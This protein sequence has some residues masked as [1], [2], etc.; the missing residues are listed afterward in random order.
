MNFEN[1]E[2]LFNPTIDGNS[3]KV[4]SLGDGL[5]SLF[6]ITLVSTLLEIENKQ[7]KDDKPLLNIFAIEEPETI[8]HSI[9]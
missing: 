8:F 1:V 4:D 9:Y 2:I 7:E 3:V 5:K 6:Y